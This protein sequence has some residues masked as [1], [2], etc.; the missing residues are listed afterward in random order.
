MKKIQYTTSK[1]NVRIVETEETVKYHGGY[2]T[3]FKADGRIYNWDTNSKT[4]E[5]YVVQKTGYIRKVGDN[6]RYV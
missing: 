3:S 6:A 4:D 2:T 5:M 1:G